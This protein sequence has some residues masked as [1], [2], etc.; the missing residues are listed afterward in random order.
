MTNLSIELCKICGIEPKTISFEI[1]PD[2][3]QPENFVKLLNFYYR[4]FQSI[5]VY[6]DDEL[7]SE[8]EARGEQISIQDKF[9]AILIFDLQHRENGFSLDINFTT[10]TQAIREMEWVYE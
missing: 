5:D 3:T 1:Y 2:F 8:L 4:F 7:V 9:L 6:A 10:F